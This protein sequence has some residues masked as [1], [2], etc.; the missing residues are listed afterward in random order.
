MASRIQDA[1]KP[2]HHLPWFTPATFIS[3]GYVSPYSIP[4]DSPYASGNSAMP[5]TAQTP[6]VIKFRVTLSG[7]AAQHSATSSPTS[8]RV[9]GQANPP[10]ASPQST[11]AGLWYEWYA[12]WIN[13]FWKRLRQEGIDL[14]ILPYSCGEVVTP[15]M[16]A[17]T[18][19]AD[20][21]IALVHYLVNSHAYIA[22]TYDRNLAAGMGYPVADWAYPE[23]ALQDRSAVLS[24]STANA[25]TTTTTII[26]V[27]H[28]L[29][30]PGTKARKRPLVCGRSIA[31][32]CQWD[33]GICSPPVPWYWSRLPQ[34]HVSSVPHVLQERE[35][36]EE[37]E[38]AE[39]AFQKRMKKVQ[40]GKIGKQ[41]PVGKREE[42]DGSEGAK[43]HPS[44]IKEK[45]ERD[46]DDLTNGSTD[47]NSADE[48]SG[49]VE[50]A[51]VADALSSV[52]DLPKKESKKEKA[53]TRRSTRLGQRP[54][55]QYGHQ[56]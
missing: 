40:Q 8:S 3:T 25:S 54:R 47:K 52:K 34:V 45:K 20:P 48:K 12:K 39:K 9:S 7:G 11:T 35:E 37:A 36:R 21:A 43:K 15:S 17:S 46:G 31:N 24:S 6:P 53:P 5:T 16:I 13:R 50:D 30:D 2:N 10:A 51:N 28:H 41:E 56:L 32:P 27:D 49:A 14:Q 33:F 55:R 44:K 1:P 4:K 38:E 18:N 42:A 26:V 29:H 22:T 23:F 19:V